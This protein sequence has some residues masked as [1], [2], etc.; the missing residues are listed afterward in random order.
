MAVIRSLTLEDIPIIAAWLPEV[1]LMQ[2]YGMTAERTRSRLTEAHAAND[3]LLTAD[4]PNETACGL[5]WCLPH[6]MFGRSPYLRLLV[7]KNGITGGGVGAALL[8]A[9]EDRLAV[10]H[11]W[12][13]L[14]VTDSNTAA[15]RFYT[16]HGYR[17][18]G[19]IGGYV[20][21][22]VVEYLFAKQLSQ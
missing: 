8:S 3:L 5:A 20:L 1:S 9:L 10:G 14:L 12:L 22:G 11:G 4:L 6:G 17:Q 15:Q 19:A 7:V 2:R 18:V 21:P 13:F 16:R